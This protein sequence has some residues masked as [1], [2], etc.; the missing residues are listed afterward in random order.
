MFLGKFNLLK[1]GIFLL[2][3]IRLSLASAAYMPDQTIVFERNDFVIH[4]DAT[5]ENYYEKVIRINTQTGVEDN[6]EISLAFNQDLEA[7]DVT[8]AYVL[9]PPWRDSL[10]AT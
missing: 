1:S 4:S 10:C 5:F 8:Q 9:Q 2:V 6:G 7:L 3:T